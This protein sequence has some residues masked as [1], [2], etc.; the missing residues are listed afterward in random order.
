MTRTKLSLSV[1]DPNANQP[2]RLSRDERVALSLDGFY[3]LV[4]AQE[5]AKSFRFLGG[6]LQSRHARR[7]RLYPEGSSTKRSLPLTGVHIA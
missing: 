5:A 3:V 2:R 4:I 7:F 1:P 6:S